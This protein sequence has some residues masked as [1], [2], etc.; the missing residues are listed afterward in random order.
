MGENFILGTFYTF[1]PNGVHRPVIRCNHMYCT[2]CGEPF[3]VGRDALF[4]HITE[5]PFLPRPSRASDHDEDGEA[6]IAETVKNSDTVL[7]MTMGMKDWSIHPVRMCDGWEC[8]CY[9]VDRVRAENKEKN[10]REGNRPSVIA[11]GRHIS[12]PPMELHRSRIEIWKNCENMT[13][14]KFHDFWVDDTLEDLV[15]LDQQPPGANDSD[16]ERENRPSTTSPED[17][18]DEG[19]EPESDTDPEGSNTEPMDS[20]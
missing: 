2:E 15:E 3:Y 9:D 1:L 13:Y 17:T 12:L 14:V 20:N 8:A 4:K 19:A 18:S 5:Y 6:T 16:D 10:E 7:G 11:R